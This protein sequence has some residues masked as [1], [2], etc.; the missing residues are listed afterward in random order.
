MTGLT[1]VRN[2]PVQ[3]T[4]Q[5]QAVA[6][7]FRDQLQY[8][9]CRFLQDP[10][11]VWEW[12]VGEDLRHGDVDNPVLRDSDISK[13]HCLRY[14]CE[15]DIWEVCYIRHIHKTAIY[16]K[17][18]MSV[19]TASPI[20]GKFAISV[21]STR[22][23]YIESSLCPLQLRARYMG[24][25]L[26]PSHLQDSDIS[27]VHCV[28]YNCE[29]DIWEVCYI[30][31]IY[32]TAI[33][34]K[35]TVSIATTRFRYMGSLLYPSHLQDSDISKVHYVRYYCE[36]DIWEVC[37]IRH[38]LKT[39]IYRK[40][41]MSVTTASPIYGK[42]A[43]SVTS[44]RLRYIGSSLCPL[45]VR[46]RYMGSL[47][48]PAHL[49]D[50]DISKVHCVRYNCEPDIWEVCYI[51]HIYKTAIYMKFTMSVTTASPIYGKFAISVTSTRLDI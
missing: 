15:P 28:R 36:P 27:K 48:Y 5:A 17:F 50:S 46:A 31:H 3:K 35:F 22:L 37:Y 9:T 51:G 14:N 19:T 4:A 7:E 29:P 13:V 6:R 8:S 42:F 1:P 44:T 49:Q 18:T 11:G 21:T 30:R 39:A 20:Y 2:Y 41:T 40:L 25:L 23:G 12:E 32:K 33:Y 34:R 38:I 24:S 10:L 16:R 43:I 45:L 47:L 26:Y